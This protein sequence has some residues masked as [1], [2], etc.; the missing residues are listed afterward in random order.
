MINALQKVDC[1]VKTQNCE[2]DRFISKFRRIQNPVQHLKIEFCA[3]RVN[4]F[5]PL[6]YVAKSSI[7]DVWF[8]IKSTSGGHYVVQTVSPL[9][10]AISS[11][12][13]GTQMDL[14][15]GFIISF[16]Q[17]LWGVNKTFFFRIRLAVLLNWTFRVLT[18]P[19]SGF[20][21]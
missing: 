9:I 11:I 17:W 1:W 8:G 4:N 2:Y 16:V 3:K 15:G 6:S 13:S 12:S 18:Q 21:C 7:P 14:K 19:F 5:E 20:F 10:K